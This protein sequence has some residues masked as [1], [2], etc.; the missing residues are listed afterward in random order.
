[1]ARSAEGEGDRAGT[2]PVCSSKK[3]VRG[4]PITL[5]LAATHLDLS[6]SVGEVSY[7]A[8]TRPSVPN[9]PCGRSTSS[10]AITA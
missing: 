9:R 3:V 4:D 10:N 2:L 6:H 5:T 8:H 1:M 7:G